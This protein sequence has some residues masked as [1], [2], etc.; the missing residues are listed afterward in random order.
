MQITLDIPDQFGVDLSP[1]EL[2]KKIKLY[3][4]LTMYKVGHLSAGAACEFAGIDRFTFI[5]ECQK[6]QIVMIDYDLNELADEFSLL[7]RAS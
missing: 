7:K 1:V 4:A 2:A 3:A 5:A 6:H